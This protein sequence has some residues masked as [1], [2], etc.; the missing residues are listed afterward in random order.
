[1]PSGDIP[2]SVGPAENV[3]GKPHTSVSSLVAEK[4]LPLS[5]LGLAF[6]PVHKLPHS[7]YGCMLRLVS[8]HRG[9]LLEGH[10]IEK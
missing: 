4:G 1:M 8:T 6:C 9:I 2:A 5:P 3:P 10:E 7:C